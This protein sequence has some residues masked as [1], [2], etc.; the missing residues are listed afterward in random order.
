MG[1]YYW[2]GTVNRFLR[3][4]AVTQRSL[5]AHD[6][7]NGPTLFQV[8]QSEEARHVVQSCCSPEGRFNRRPPKAMERPERYA[9]MQIGPSSSMAHANLT[10]ESSTEL[11]VRVAKFMFTTSGTCSH[12]ACASESLFS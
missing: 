1:F 10:P 11:P 6:H 9:V 5:V 3:E 2:G 12:G 7:A 8:F 4:H